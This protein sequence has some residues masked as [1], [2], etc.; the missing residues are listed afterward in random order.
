MKI[1]S[2]S[3]LIGQL[4]GELM[5][6]TSFVVKPSVGTMKVVNNKSLIKKIR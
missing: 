3:S 2:S 1:T 6:D 5:E 4:D